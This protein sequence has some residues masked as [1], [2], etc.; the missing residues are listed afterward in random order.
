MDLHRRSLRQDVR[1]LGALLGDIL[2][3]QTSQSGFETVETLRTAAI[4]Y[5]RGTAESRSELLE[6]LSDLRPSEAHVVARAF[7]TYF[8]LINLAEERERVRAI[9]SASQAGTLLDSLED[10]VEVLAE[11]PETAEQVLSDVR[12]EPTFT[13][14]PTEA[15]RKT[16]KAKLR[17]IASDLAE[18][19]ERTLTEKETS[20]VERDL[21][22]AVTSL[23][24]T[25]QLRERRPEPEDEARNVQWYLA[26]SLFDVVGEVYG[27]LETAI[28]RS[29][30][31]CAVPD[32]FQFR[33]WA[34]SDRDGNPFVTPDVTSRTLE[35]QRSVA[36]DRYREDVDSLISVLSQDGA[37]I[38]TGEAFETSLAADRER[39]PEV[40]S[41]ARD[42]Y[43]NEPYRQKLVLVKER[44]DRVGDVRPGGYD[45]AD[46]FES[47]L[48]VIA[49]SLRSNGAP[50]I[51]EAEVD[52]MRRRV[53]TFGFT[54]AS[55]DLRD[56][57]ENHTR[58][59][60]EILSREGMEYQNLEEDERQAVL[61]EAILQEQ[62]IVDVSDT[63]GLSETPSRVLDRFASLAEWQD[64]Y[65]MAAIDAYCI[66]MTEEVSHVLEVLFL[67]DQAGV[68]VLP[69]HS[70]IDVVPLL[71]TES[72]LSRARSIM[73]TLFENEAYAQALAARGDVQEVMIGYSDSNKENGFLSAN[74]SLYRN[75][76]RLADIT[77]DYDV[78]LR[79]FH[80]RGGSI[81][82]GGGPMNEALLALPRETV[83]GQVKFTVQGEAIAESYAN[84]RIA[85]RELEQ[86]LNAQIRARKR[87][88]EDP[89][90]DLR[91]T[92]TTS[93]ET[94]AEAARDTYLEL[95][96]T[97]G[98]VSYFEQATPIT[99]IEDLNLGSRPSSRT[100]ERNV[101]DLRAIPWVFAWTQSR[102]ILPGW[103]GLGS[104]IDA[105]LE[106][107]GD[108]ET[109]QEMYT[110]WPFF[111]TTVDNAALALARTDMEIAA[112]Y[113]D[114][115]RPDL[116]E[117]FFPRIEEEYDR[118]VERVLAVTDRDSLLKR[119]WLAESLRRRNP[120]VDPLN[121]LQADLLGRTHRSEE[122]ERVLRLT[123]KGIAA[124]MKN[125]G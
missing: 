124:G 91:S 38:D 67:A 122:E 114:L 20:H 6:E 50:T 104:G 117:R 31:D 45:D 32:L 86:M 60:G 17:S 102:C 66:S 68:V 58:T 61:T 1:E 95:L 63:E 52:P 19:D 40:S 41:F 53:A 12:I 98:F 11:D 42:R 3:E 23:W 2:A 54:L 80:G 78:T 10:A 106:T 27:E 83:N 47:D 24:Q 108:V 123:V 81:S 49:S 92:W 13:A 30:L 73:G 37:R 94:M 109:L 107:G 93:M 21:D 57:R 115:A 55:H 112:E 65:G 25:P 4:A 96:T 9:R 113:A 70:G 29:D 90:E 99:V 100:G 85:E 8:E 111:R 59:V 5:R 119:E 69:E 46:A 56:H 35:R 22:A 79:L 84:K 103:Y 120:Y 48:E 82:R 28:D 34:G 14:H 110:E 116:E 76:R 26:N 44:L 51:A 74:W 89:V 87:A 121:L 101:E 105:Y 62:P 75:Q 125:T 43:P 72:A 64:E 118:T 77:G 88:I 15:R 33:S 7:T 39:L 36:L 18:L 97:A 16:V 71:E